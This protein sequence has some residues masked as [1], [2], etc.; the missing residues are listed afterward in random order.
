MP[1][2]SPSSSGEAPAAPLQDPAP[3]RVSSTR[4][5]ADSPAD[6]TAMR[7]TSDGDTG[8]TVA[9]GSSL[10]SFVMD[11][12]TAAAPTTARATHR[13]EA[14]TRTASGDRGCPPDNGGV[15]RLRQ[16]ASFILAAASGRPTA[17]AAA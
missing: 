8:S 1:D 2:I 9:G 11:R 7:R 10:R 12:L 6:S 15:S 16:L 14:T 5:L 17:G 4:P 3:D 13:D